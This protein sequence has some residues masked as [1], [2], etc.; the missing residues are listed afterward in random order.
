MCVCVC[1][2]VCAHTWAHIHIGSLYFYESTCKEARG[3][4]TIPTHRPA[5]NCVIIKW[6]VRLTVFDPSCPPT[7]DEACWHYLSYDRNLCYAL[8][9]AT[10]Q[11]MF[12]TDPLADL[13]V[14]PWALVTAVTTE[15]V[16]NGSYTR[17]AKEDKRQKFTLVRSLDAALFVD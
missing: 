2:C 13:R 9:Y 12:V 10:H 5:C 4:H 14:L 11:P 7:R 6:S 3:M 17:G 1:V 8:R 16:P 15:L